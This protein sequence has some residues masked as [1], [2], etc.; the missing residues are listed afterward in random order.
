ME[1]LVEQAGLTVCASDDVSCPFEYPD[2][3][4]AWKTIKQ[5]VLAS[6]VPFKSPGGGYRQEN[7]FHYLIA[8]A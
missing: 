4:T 7:L 5:T 2:D 1:A 3:E 8:T 6:L